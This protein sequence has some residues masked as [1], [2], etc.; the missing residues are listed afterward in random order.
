MLLL[1]ILYLPINAANSAP[2]L[3]KLLCSVSS[4]SLLVKLHFQEFIA[5]IDQPHRRINQCDVLL[6]R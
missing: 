1:S 3:F 6:F 2:L 4:F 5:L